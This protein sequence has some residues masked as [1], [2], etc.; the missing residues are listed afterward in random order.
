LIDLAVNMVGA[1]GAQI[2]SNGVRTVT[3]LKYIQR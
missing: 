3:D 2:Q 1:V